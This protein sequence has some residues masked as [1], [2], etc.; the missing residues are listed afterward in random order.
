MSAW[1][2]SLSLQVAEA[3]VS[4]LVKEA[5][6][7]GSHITPVFAH[8]MIEIITRQLDAFGGQYVAQKVWQQVQASPGTFTHTPNGEAPPDDSA[9]TEGPVT[10]QG[11]PVVYDN[12]PGPWGGDAHLGERREAVS[13]LGTARLKGEGVETAFDR[14]VMGDIAPTKKGKRGPKPKGKKA[15]KRG[16]TAALAA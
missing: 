8:R 11:T 10:F 2:P 16:R 7:G 3:T 4:N 1:K 5:A 13:A 9:P 6:A 14:D 12:T 15:G